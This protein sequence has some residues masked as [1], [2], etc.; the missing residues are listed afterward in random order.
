MQFTFQIT[1]SNSGRGK[2]NYP[3]SEG[4]GP[5]KPSKIGHFY[6]HRTIYVMPFENE[7][8]Y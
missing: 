7:T 2:N 5:S 8:Q 4:S 6:Y 3:I 1:N